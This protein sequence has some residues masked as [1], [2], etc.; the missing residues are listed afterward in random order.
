MKHLYQTIPILLAVL[1]FVMPCSAQVLL[2]DLWA[3]GSRAEHNLPTE[4]AWFSS[5]SSGASLTAAVGSMTG[6]IPSGSVQWMTYYTAAGSPA[7]LNVGDTLKAT[8]IFTPNGVAALNANRGLRIG[9][10]NFASGGTRVS[11]NGYSTG[12]GT[13]AP[14]ANVLGYMLNMNFGDSFGVDA[15]LQI[16]ERTTTASINLMG[17]SGDY[18]ALSSGP[19]G[20]LNDPAF[21]SGTQ[22]TLEFSVTRT[23]VDSVDITTRFVGGLLDISHTATDASGA[24]FA[25]DNFAIR[26]AGSA[27]GATSL[28]FSEFKVEVVPE[29]SSVALAGL[30]LLGLT[31]WRIWVRRFASR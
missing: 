9:L 11:A 20:S 22:Y 12:A 28:V 10:F 14:G 13:G 29:P 21:S 16:M 8:A 31:G 30:A 7:T 5:D 3:D 25:F 6:A 23:A 26:P 19:T 2:D 1:Q 27:Q 17:A 18:T 24:T 15:P 4:S